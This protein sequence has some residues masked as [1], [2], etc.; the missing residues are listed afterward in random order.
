MRQ[1][2]LCALV[3][4]SKLSNFILHLRRWGRIWPEARFFT[5]IRSYIG[6]FPLKS[7]VVYDCWTSRKVGS[8]VVCLAWFRFGDHIASS[9]HIA[10]V[11]HPYLP[12]PRANF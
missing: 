6:W 4:L 8:H 11:F 3:F 10:G 5:G 12:E 7:V 9:R 2:L 1:L